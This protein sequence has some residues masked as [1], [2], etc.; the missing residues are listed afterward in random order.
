MIYNTRVGASVLNP[1]VMQ[2]PRQL[3]LVFVLRRRGIDI[4][5]NDLKCGKTIKNRPEIVK[6]PDNTGKLFSP[7]S[8]HLNLYD[9]DY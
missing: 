4:L 1:I 7:F 9:L 5:R 6:K 2:I 3:L 8:D